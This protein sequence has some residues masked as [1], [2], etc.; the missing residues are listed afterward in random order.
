[1]TFVRRYK[2]AMRRLTPG[3]LSDR[4][5]R[6]LNRPPRLRRRRWAGA[7]TVAVALAVILA[8]TWLLRPGTV[9]GGGVPVALAAPDYPAST[10]YQ[11]AQEAYRQ[12]PRPSQDYLTALED[13]SYAAAGSLLKTA[14]GNRLCSPLSLALTLSMLAEGAGGETQRILLE[15]LGMED[16]AALRQETA[17]LYRL[18][19]TDNEVGCLL[20]A[21]S[22][23]LDRDIAFRQETLDILARDYYAAAFHA[24]L[25]APE[26]AQAI[27]DWIAESTRGK[28]GGHPDAFRQDGS[29]GMLL[30]NT[31]YFY[32]QWLVPFAESQTTPQ[33]FTLEDG[34]QVQADMMHARRA[35]VFYQGEGFTAA[36]LPFQNDA[37]MVFVLPDAGGSVDEFLADGEKLA[38]CLTADQSP[39][40]RTGTIEFGVPRF[41]YEVQLDLREGM[42]ALGLGGLFTQEADFSGFSSELL[43]LASARQGATITVDEK[44]CEAAAY[45]EMAA[46]AAG[47]MIQDTCTLILDRPFLYAVVS[48]SGV[49]LFVGTVA[50]PAA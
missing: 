46:L 34:S 22:L 38:R 2:D 32:D 29:V 13:F 4:V 7:A 5:L 26:T 1:M 41:S 17:K 27:A 45:T 40:A 12:A 33:P 37:R 24:D 30:Y 36:S 25:D 44:G 31:L 9:P 8:V 19:Y 6:G 50:N 10:T 15:A 14:Q 43:C 11:E 21:Q 23:W 39:D 35:G 47:A 18:L 48:A 16:T 3:G 20:P 28:L 42:E 49:P